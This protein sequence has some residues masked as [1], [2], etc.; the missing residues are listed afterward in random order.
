M[1][2]QERLR[3]A[4]AQQDSPSPRRPEGGAKA[5]RRYRYH[6]RHTPH[7]Y[8]VITSLS[9]AAVVCVLTTAAFAER[10]VLLT[11]VAFAAIVVTALV[12]CAAFFWGFF[13]L[14]DGNIPAHRIRVL[15]PH[16]A[17]GVLSPLLYT[18]N[19]AAG[20]DG[21][22]AASAGAV[23]VA[24]SYASLGVL[25]IQFAMGRSVVRPEPLKGLRRIDTARP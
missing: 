10:S 4:P 12:I 24:C 13:M 25:C 16:A 23:S 2:S 1:S 22:G 7:F 18:L 11:Q 9:C 20:L 19:I 5:R 8:L 6:R 15:I 17:V 21:L 14:M 3:I